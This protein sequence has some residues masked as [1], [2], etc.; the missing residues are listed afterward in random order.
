MISTVTATEEIYTAAE[1]DLPEPA[2]ATGTGKKSDDRPTVQLPGKDA[3]LIPFFKRL[4]EALGRC[5]SNIYQKNDRL[6]VAEVV[7][8]DGKETA[9]LRAPS[10]T[11]LCEDV[12][13][14]VSLV[15]V[16]FKKAAPKKSADGGVEV[17]DGK[18]VPRDAPDDAPEEP[19]EKTERKVCLPDTLARKALESVSLKAALREIRTAEQVL[20]PVIGVDGKLIKLKS[21]YDA[22][23]KV[24]SANSVSYIT[25]MPIET[26]KK[27]MDEWFGQ[28]RFGDDG[29]SKAVLIA[30]AVSEFVRY[31]MPADVLR[32]VG[33]SQCNAPGGGKTIGLQMAMGPVHGFVSV[34]S[35]PGNKEELEKK[36]ASAFEGGK[37]LL[38]FD[39]VEGYCNSDVICQIVTSPKW[40]K[41]T[42]GILSNTEY[43]HKSQLLI[44]GNNI[45]IGPDLARRSMI[46]DLRQ[47]VERPELQLVERPFSGTMLEANRPT[48]LAALWSLTANWI[49]EGKPCKGTVLGTFVD[50]STTVGGIVTA[51]GFKDPCQVVSVADVDA[52]GNDART[53]VTSLAEGIETFAPAIDAKH[54]LTPQVIREW[55]I[56]E[57]LFD[58]LLGGTKSINSIASTAGKILATWT[59]RDCAGYRLKHDGNTN[60]ARRKYWVEKTENH[61]PRKAP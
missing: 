14:N 40:E 50:W 47:T 53:L 9:R 24:F 11:S 2:P 57:E 44:S 3:E 55:M 41:R 26:A 52:N 46:C 49:A 38:I 7:T 32:P 39:N 10:S 21:G 15:K 43:E 4:G 51:A 12:E 33:I 19:A 31:L 61:E 37:R 25:D 36:V 28:F 17:I 48:L 56:K 34:M 5:S 16:S 1:E 18:V 59:N 45:R 60:N 27:T 29:R 54:G 35:Y 42:L 22:S 20:L 13:K 6:Y 23:A 30:F 58:S 8:V